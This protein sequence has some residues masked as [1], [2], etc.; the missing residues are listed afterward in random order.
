MSRS[1]ESTA[2]GLAD[3]AL[4]P[5]FVARH[6]AAPTSFPIVSAVD[7]IAVGSRWTYRRGR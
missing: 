6:S 1:P 7:P 5:R 4:H 2:V 3:A